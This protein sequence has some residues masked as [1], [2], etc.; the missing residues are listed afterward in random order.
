MF[1]YAI[2][3]TLG[4]L[5]A[6]S[7]WAQASDDIPL[8][9][10]PAAVRKAADIAAP[11]MRWK[12]AQSNINDDKAYALVGADDK[13]RSVYVVVNP[14]GKVQSVS[15]TITLKEVPKSVLASIG[16]KPA[17]AVVLQNLVS[18]ETIGPDS[19]TLQSYRF[20]ADVPRQRR[21]DDDA[22]PDPERIADPERIEEEIANSSF[23]F[24]FYVSPQG[25]V[26]GWPSAQ[27]LLGK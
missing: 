26:K 18:I 24:S 23:T 16:K 15:T 6:M 3:L 13:G 17:G 22:P 1:R 19:K 9:K 5:L 12:S 7:G 10:V 2:G 21:D 20:V 11:K 4:L 27:E 14:D 25:A 8:E